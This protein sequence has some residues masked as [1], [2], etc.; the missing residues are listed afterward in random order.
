[1]ARN[2]YS[3]S[4]RE[5][6]VNEYKKGES[7][8]SIAKKFCVDHSV[9]SRTLSRFRLTGSLETSHQGG[10]PRKTTKREDQGIVRAIKKDP[11]IS[12]RS[13]QSELHSNIS[14]RSIQR[15]AVDGGL[16][17]YRSVKKPFISPKNR[18]AR[19]EFA[20]A[21]VNWTV[22]KWRTVLFS[23][24]S[25]FNIKGSDGFKLV[26]RPKGQR[27][28]PRYST[29]TVKHGG[30]N[31]IVWGCFSGHGIGPIHRIDGI[32]DRFMYKDIL[33]DVML[34][35]AEEEMPLK[36]IFQHDN[37]PKHT[38][39]CVKEWLSVKKIE[40]LD[41]PAQ[42]PDLNPIENLW[43]IVDRKIQREN[44]KG[45][46]SLFT[47]AELAWRSISKDVLNNLIE[48]MPRRCEAVLKSNGYATKY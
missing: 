16:R 7:V 29:G 48:S 36:W 10:R 5:K 27:L 24:E 44:C 26:R 34:P 1:M 39:K 4:F 3:A 6:I 20:R 8:T 25:K 45:K 32:M 22:S 13:I 43:E 35:H 9:V 19:I 37:D 47:Q 31:V 12:A 30:G 14:L 17:T 40:V 21:H 18:R 41:W 11:F 28:N 15:R 38:A 42:S 33:Q 2:K 46:D 23:D